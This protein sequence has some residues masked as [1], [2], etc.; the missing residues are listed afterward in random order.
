MHPFKEDIIL[1]ILTMFNFTREIDLI[2]FYRTEYQKEWNLAVKNGIKLS[3][4]DIRVR[5]ENFPK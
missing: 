1:G 3:Y 2:T 4:S 5:L